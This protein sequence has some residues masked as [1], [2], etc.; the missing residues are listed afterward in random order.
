MAY[1][2]QVL[3]AHEG[4][5]GDREVRR[6]AHDGLL[7]AEHLSEITGREVRFPLH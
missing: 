6:V 5:A 3:W 4:V 1:Y 7:L 2:E